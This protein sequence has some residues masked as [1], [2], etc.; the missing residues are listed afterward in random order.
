LIAEIASD[1]AHDIVLIIVIDP[2]IDC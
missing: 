1:G 2:L